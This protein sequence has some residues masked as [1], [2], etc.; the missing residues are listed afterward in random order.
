M[1][2]KIRSLIK[3][4][5]NECEKEKISLL[6]T[7]SDEG[8]AISSIQGN[9]EDVAFCMAIQE[10]KLSEVL[11]ISVE[12]VRQSAV[13]ALKEARSDSQQHTF[14]IENEEDLKDM[15]NRIISGEFD[16]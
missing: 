7:V 5:G 15:L 1:N 13:S 2:R 9:F 8:E 12:K 4:L 6:C 14:V 10:Q 3:E 11:P 16:E